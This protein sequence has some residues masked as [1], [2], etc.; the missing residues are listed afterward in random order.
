MNASY[1]LLMLVR[2]ERKN[3][4]FLIETSQRSCFCHKD[5]VGFDTKLIGN[6]LEIVIV[7]KGSNLQGKDVENKKIRERFRD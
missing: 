7:F 5:R 1:F 4:V 6:S 2:I 3:V